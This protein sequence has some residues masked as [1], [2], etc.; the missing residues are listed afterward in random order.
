MKS[1]IDKSYDAFLSFLQNTS[2]EELNKM[3]DEVNETRIVGEPT[4]Q[5]YFAETEKQLTSLYMDSTNSL[6]DK[7]TL[8]E[9]VNDFMI[10]N[11][12]LSSVD[13]SNVRFIESD[14][15]LN[16]AYIACDSDKEQVVG[17][18]A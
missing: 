4:I 14:I 11:A 12:R 13:T 16:N 2:K 10:Y 1:I 5:E 6:F 17:D 9:E 7:F 18:A 15:T 8:L 3:V